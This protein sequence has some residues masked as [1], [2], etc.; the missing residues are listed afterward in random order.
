MLGVIVNS[1][2]LCWDVIHV[3]GPQVGIPSHLDGLGLQPCIR[4]EHCLELSC[5]AIVYTL[6]SPTLYVTLRPKEKAP[7]DAKAMSGATR[8]WSV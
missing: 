7:V 5:M 4:R 2:V 3:S 1:E 8:S 6:L